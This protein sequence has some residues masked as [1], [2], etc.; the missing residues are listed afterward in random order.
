MTFYKKKFFLLP[1]PRIASRYGLA[2][3]AIAFLLLCT[4]FAKAEDAAAA[5][6]SGWTEYSF[7]AFDDAHAS[8]SRVL[9]MEP[10][11]AEAREARIGMAMIQQFDERRGNIKS[12]IEI[13]EQLL[14]EEITG[15]PAALV[16]S[17]LAEC[18][19]AEGRLSEAG[20][21]WDGVISEFPDSIVAQDALVQRTYAFMQ[22][23]DSHATSQSITNML[24]MQA[25]FPTPTPQKPG[26]FPTMEATAGNYYYWKEMYSESRDAFIRYTDIANTR[27]TSYAW[28]AG[29]LYR[30]ARI[31]ELLLN[32]PVTA[33]RYY[34]RMVMETRNAPQSWYALMQAV[35]LESINK[36]EV[37][38]L[39]IPGL[40]EATIDRLFR[41]EIVSP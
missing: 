7:L 30:I 39:R 15:E 24:Q 29:A 17:L 14:N 18:Y 22:D 9:E 13:Y 16:R 10:S 38:A 6:A 35:R 31:S 32:D 8:F 36:E 37:R 3:G 41:G 33:G 11:P 25:S 21:L 20:K 12:A 19:A 28:V 26:L 5:L 34:R 2:A 23:W 27:N 1:K 40:D 4:S